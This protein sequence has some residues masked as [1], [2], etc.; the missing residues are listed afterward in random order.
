MSGG[1]DWFGGSR[2]KKMIKKNDNVSPGLTGEMCENAFGL[3]FI[4][5]GVVGENLFANKKKWHFWTDG[6]FGSINL[7]SWSP[8]SLFNNTN[9]CSFVF[10]GVEKFFF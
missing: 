6:F 5:R 4:S 8:I 3:S 2:D 1:W 9:T 10:V 7:K